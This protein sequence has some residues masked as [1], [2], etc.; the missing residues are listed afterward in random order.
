[1][2]NVEHLKIL[3]QGVTAWNHWRSQHPD[4]LP[5]LTAANLDGAL[6]REA[7]LEGADLAGASLVG[8]ELIE[9]D[10]GRAQ[11]NGVTFLGSNLS[12]AYLGR[13][14]LESA[15]FG[16]DK[17]SCPGDGNVVSPAKLRE[18]KLEGARLI[19]AKL[20]GV[21]LVR[22]NLEW[23]DLYGAN[24]SKADLREAS[25][26][27]ANLSRA[28]LT[29]SDLE[30]AVIGYTVFG[31]SDLNNIKLDGICHRGPSTIGIE[32]VYRSQGKISEVF[33]RGAGV[34]ESFITYMKSLVGTEKAFE[35]YSCFISY[36]TK[37]QG[38]A[39][40][41]YADLQAKG[42]RCW[43]AP[44]DVKA[45]RK[46][47]E[48]IDEAIRLYERLLLILSPNSMNSEWVK[49][50]IAKARKGEIRENRRVLFPIRLV[51]FAELRDWECFDADTGKDSAREIREYFI[52]DFS[53]WKDH[54]SY[55]AAFRRL[56]SDLKVDDPRPA[57]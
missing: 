34:P 49:T 14:N 31:D 37:D 57:L 42:V 26:R 50:E 55:Q 29:N 2:A 48:Q 41:V 32:T 11:L 28:D 25:L 51:S 15:C 19:W 45:G 16:N 53:S 22:A 13:A 23:A 35:F 1:M 4:V 12:G 38:F 43:F 52:P 3:K 33:L 39:D 5:D 8:A 6:L 18:A 9:A 36:S 47:H 46:L 21:D 27:F 7:Y 17:S 40:R 44:H 24:L 20:A 10:L 54:D 56:V 30:G